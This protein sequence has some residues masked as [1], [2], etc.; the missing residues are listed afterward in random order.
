L[1]LDRLNRALLRSRNQEG[2]K[3]AVLL[4]DMDKFADLEERVGHAAADSVLLAVSRRIA[5]LLRP[6]DTVARLN[7]DQFAVILVTEQ[8][9]SRIAEVAEQI[10]RA[11]RAPFNFGDRDLA[12]SASIGITIYDNSAADAE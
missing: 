9:P 3:P 5:R 8:T 4:I 12:L 1:L 2:V 11:I 10:R 6:L 7:G